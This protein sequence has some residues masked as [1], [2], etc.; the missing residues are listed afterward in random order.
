MKCKDHEWSHF[1]I[2]E[3]FDDSGEEIEDWTN[4]DISICKSCH[5]VCFLVNNKMIIKSHSQEKIDT[6]LELLESTLY[7]LT[8]PHK[9]DMTSSI[10][11]IKIA[12]ELRKKQLL[13]EDNAP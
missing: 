1:F 13:E 3:V 11:K 5:E 9:D 12:I 4:G 8:R 2:K 10:D 6:I 7:Q